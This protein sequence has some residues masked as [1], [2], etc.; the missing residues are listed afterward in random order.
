M[1]LVHR[2]GHDAEGLAAKVR[3]VRH[4][5]AERER[6]PHQRC[7]ALLVELCQ[8]RAPLLRLVTVDAMTTSTAETTT[9]TIQRIQSI[10]LDPSP[11]KSE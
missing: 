2:S 4:P 1:W 7:G 8:A 6:A 9:A 3:G 5:Y 11:P 10:P